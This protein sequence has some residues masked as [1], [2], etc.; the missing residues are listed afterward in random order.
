MLLLRFIML[1]VSTAA[2][3][4]SGVTLP[5]IGAGM[6]VGY[7]NNS[8]YLLGSQGFPY[9][10]VEYPIGQT[11]IDHG[12]TY[13]TTGLYDGTQYYYQN[14]NILYMIDRFDVSVDEGTTLC[15]FNLETKEFTKYWNSITLQ[16]TTVTNCVAST[17]SYLF[18]VGG[19][20]P[21]CTDG[22]GV[23]TYGCQRNIV[24]ILT[25][26]G[27]NRLTWMSN[28]PTMNRA[29][30]AFSCVIHPSTNTLYAIGGHRGKA[31]EGVYDWGGKDYYRTIEKLYIGGNIPSQSWQ[32]TRGNLS[33]PAQETRAVVYGDIIYV[34]GGWFFNNYITRLTVDHLIDVVTGDV[35]VL[36]STH[37]ELHKTAAIIH[38]NRLYAFGGDNRNTWIYY[39]LPTFD[40]TNNP[41][42]P[43]SNTPSQSPSDSPSKSPTKSPSALTEAPT[44]DPS[45][46][47][48]NNPS[49]SPSGV[50]S[51][52]PTGLPTKATD[53]PSAM[54][55]SPTM[56]P[57]ASPTENPSESPHF[58]LQTEEIDDTWI[59]KIEGEHCDDGY[60]DVDE[61]SAAYGKHCKRCNARQA[62]TS[63]ECFECGTFEEPNFNHTD[64]E[65]V[66]PWWLYLLETLAGLVCMGGMIGGIYQVFFVKKEDLKSE[67]TTTV[68]K[69]ELKKYD[70]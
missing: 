5:R 53:N 30:T 42:K 20:D 33:L 27:S 14:G 43:P 69:G 13:F 48:S 9:Q 60:T 49:E 70:L 63:G 38:G 23:Y 52:S 39:D 32:Y 56:Y 57:S 7:F 47:P 22:C 24:Q 66:H 10:F 36:A 58:A 55:A 50:P 65:F 31:A 6:A 26:V 15:T 67:S 68:E 64:C 28:T 3:I 34:I 41:S 54:S 2:W 59:V 45:S 62:G 4:Q 40:P 46:S 25:L 17:D 12:E 8:I 21:G 51:A 35:S 18:I 29:R 61:Q 16:Y 19:C 44:N 11:F 37:Y 1:I